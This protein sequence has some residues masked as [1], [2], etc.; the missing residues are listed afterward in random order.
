[1]GSTDETVSSIC[2]GVGPLDPTPG[3][4]LYGVAIYTDAGG[5]PGTLIASNGNGT[6]TVANGFNCLSIS[7]VLSA[8]QSYWLVYNNNGDD[9][10]ANPTVNNLTYNVASSPIGGYSSP[11]AFGNWPSPFPNFTAEFR[12]YALY[13]NV[14]P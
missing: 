10:G 1:V 6:L 8:G 13:A 9:K 3:N 5:A 4:N 2:A 11:V 7:A 12:Q 14:S